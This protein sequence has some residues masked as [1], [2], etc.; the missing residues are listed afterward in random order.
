MP[1]D[2]RG[3]GAARTATRTTPTVRLRALGWD[4]DR[5]MRPMLACAEAWAEQNPAVEISWERR[6]LTDFGDQPLEDVTHRFDLVVIDHPFCGTAAELGCLRPLDELL[7][8]ETLGALRADAVGPSHRSYEFGG[9]QWGLATDA[10]CQVAAVRPDLLGGRRVPVTWD[11]VTSLAHELAGRVALPLSPPHAL[12]SFLTLCANAGAAV[13][14]QSERLVDRATG[15]HAVAL[16]LEL[17]RLGPGEAVDWEPPD[18][19]DRLS[20]TD[21]LVYVPLTYSYVTYADAQRTIVGPT[22]GQ[23]GSRAAWDDAKLDEACGGF[24]SGTR[25]TIDAAWVRPRDAWWPLFQLEG[26]IALTQALRDQASPGAALDA[27]E[28]AYHDARTQRS[29]A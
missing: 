13:A 18:A 12:S 28:A 11:E 14:E 20:G 23:P 6:S 3:D 17:A 2:Q 22:G 1:N 7:A 25:A 26:G 29:P 27:V 24:F 16:L 5:C 10:A 15:E 4:H 8:P 21:D 9:H 19:L